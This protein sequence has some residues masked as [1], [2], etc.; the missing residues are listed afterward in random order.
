MRLGK[1][2]LVPGLRGA[3]VLIIV[4]AL[5]LVVLWLV[6]AWMTVDSPLM[7]RMRRRAVSRGWS[8]ELGAVVRSSQAT[9]IAPTSL[10]LHPCPVP[11]CTA[12]HAT[13]RSLRAH[14]GCRVAH[15]LEDRRAIP[16]EWLAAN[17]FIS[18]V[19]CAY[20]V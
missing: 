10:Q 11:R 1:R 3:T 7:S 20:P 18:C 6:L 19:Q 15:Q 9:D 14:L 4:R 13:L 5:S 2:G 17:S 16:A 8:R 12:V